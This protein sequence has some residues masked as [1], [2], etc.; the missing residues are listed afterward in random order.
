MRGTKSPTRRP[1]YL[2]YVPSAG[3]R[4][5]RRPPGEPLRAGPV[6][7]AVRRY[8]LGC[9]GWAYD[10]WVGPFYAP[11]T[12]PAEYLPRYARVFRTVEVDSSFYRAPPPSLVRRWADV[13]PPE[14]RFSLKVPRDV[15]HAPPGDPPR[16]EALGQF[17]SSLEPLRATGR[18]GALVLQFPASFR[19]GEG[20]RLA[21]LLQAVP[22]GFPVAVEL[23]HSSWWTAETRTLLERRGAALV[24]SVVPH[25][26]PPAWVTADFLYTRF[27]GDRALTRF[28]RVQRD[29]TADL[30]RMRALWDAEGRETV[31]VFAYSNNHF[32]GFAPGTVEL[33]AR[34][35]GEPRP[36]LT[37]AAR[38][39]GQ[40]RIDPEPGRT[41]PKL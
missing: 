16:D 12:P 29:Q 9:S 28:D 3:S 2:G 26:R 20:N 8:W 34:L 1:E 11:G 41:P 38:V 6:F 36:D 27:V 30:E 21:H 31:S 4:R 10:D 35:L 25:T 37:A 19:A 39:R 32:M 15:T 24:W 40:Q 33:L 17:V 18:L 22:D 7:R 13:T 5:T 23:R 14:F